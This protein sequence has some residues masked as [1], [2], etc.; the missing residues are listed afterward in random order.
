M[1]ACRN[2]GLVN[3]TQMLLISEFLQAGDFLA[4]QYF[5]RLSLTVTAKEEGGEGWVVLPWHEAI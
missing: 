4:C 1:S 2:T 3:A 5:L